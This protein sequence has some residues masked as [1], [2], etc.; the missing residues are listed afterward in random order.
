MNK[1]RIITE[2][3][4]QAGYNYEGKEAY[5]KLALNVLR[6]IARNL[7]LPKGSYSVRFN[8]GGI[9][10]AGDAILH[11]DKFYL[12]C[13]ESGIMFRRCEGQKDYGGQMGYEYRNQWAYGFD[14]T[15]DQPALEVALREMISPGAWNESI[16]R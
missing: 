16:S 12:S 13:G 11:H 15:M 9:A 7:G 4:R 3:A 8:K 10:V 1:L 2:L 6:S 14:A 5:K